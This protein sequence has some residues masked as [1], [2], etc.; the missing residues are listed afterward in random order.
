MSTLI[1]PK[2]IDREG[3][4][5]DFNL[6]EKTSKTI[7][8]TYPLIQDGYLGPYVKF[9]WKGSILS[10]DAICNTAGVEDTKI[11]IERIS[12]KDFELGVDS[13]K[14]IFMKDREICIPSSALFQDEKYQLSTIG[15]EKGDL[16]RINFLHTGPIAAPIDNLRIRD[17][18]IQIHIEV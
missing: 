15:I 3:L 13:W 8:F 2:Q 12:R 16:F 17:L 11:D 18:T 6:N 4:K 5:K 1:S 7:V 9:D 10:V 14:S